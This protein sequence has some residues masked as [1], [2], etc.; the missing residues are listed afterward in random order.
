MC[1]RDSL[2]TTGTL[3]C[4]GTALYCTDDATSTFD[5]CGGGDD[6]C[7]PTSADGSEQGGFGT[8]CDSTADTDL[9]ATGSMVC[10][11]TSL[12]CSDDATSLTD[13][14]DGVDNDCDPAS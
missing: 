11:G 1:I 13:V 8:T 6:D 10:S 7:D 5:L 2:C 3:A 14:C 9:C 12:V 4:N